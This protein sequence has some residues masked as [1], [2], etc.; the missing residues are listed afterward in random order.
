MG[1]KK[2]VSEGQSAYV[3]LCIIISSRVCEQCMRVNNGKS[4][5]HMSTSY[6]SEIAQQSSWLSLWDLAL[7]GGTVGTTG[8]QN[9]Y[10]ELTR[11]VLT[12]KCHLCLAELNREKPYFD[13]FI[14]KHSPHSDLLSSKEVCKQL[15]SKNVSN[16]L[17]KFKKIMNY[18]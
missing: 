12:P 18:P 10:R 2:K 17:T 16:L 15:A 5:D 6:A 7:D 13:H 1:I 4:T 8:L 3:T 11:P 14:A 9:L